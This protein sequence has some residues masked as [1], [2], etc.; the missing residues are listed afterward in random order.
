MDLMSLDT[1]SLEDL[2][3]LARAQG[4][5]VEDETDRDYVVGLLQA[6]VAADLASSSPPP[7]SPPPPP[8]SR[9]PGA[10]AASP[11]PP[12]ADTGGASSSLSPPRHFSPM[13]FGSPP[14]A[15]AGAGAGAG[16]AAAGAPPRQQLSDILAL[17]GMGRQPGDTSSSVGAEIGNRGSGYGDDEQSDR[18][19]DEDDMEA[20]F[21]HSSLS[22][23]AVISGG[24]AAGATGAAGVAGAASAASAG[25]SA[26]SRLAGM[27]ESEAKER[28]EALELFMAVTQVGS[29]ATAGQFL[30]ATDWSPDAAINLFLESG[31]DAAAM[32][33]AAAGRSMGGGSMGYGADARSGGGGA[34]GLRGARGSGY[35]DDD[36]EVREEERE[37]MGWTM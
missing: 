21:S 1:T 37:G 10:A 12:A 8:P 7:P 27:D 23:A 16:A 25:A 19:M 14:P 6:S 9:F 13:S 31:G 15:G 35:D 18:G 30:D 11:V 4:I 3:A 29:S 26:G 20:F 22:T 28:R 5:H 24:G 33:T 17:G 34:L 32:A 2:V 36:G